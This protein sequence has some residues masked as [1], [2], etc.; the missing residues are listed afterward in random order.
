[1]LS[2]ALAVVVLAPSSP[3]QSSAD[4]P[5]FGGPARDH[6]APALD[7]D[8]AWGDGGPKVLWRAAT[9]PGFGGA[10]VQ[11]GEVFLLDHELGESETLRVIELE[12]GAEKWRASYAIEGRQQFPGSRTVPTV[13]ADAV[14]TC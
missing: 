4:W 12:T 6:R 10:A 5:C 7:T 9:G 2:L 14:Y 3:P 8:F 13:T 1:M 11:G